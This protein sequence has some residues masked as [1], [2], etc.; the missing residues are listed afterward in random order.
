MTDTPMAEA[1]GDLL[2]EALSALRELARRA[3]DPFDQVADDDVWQSDEFRAAVE[4]AK[5]VIARADAA[6]T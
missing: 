2:G 4:Q 6:G 5:S 1:K 3:Q